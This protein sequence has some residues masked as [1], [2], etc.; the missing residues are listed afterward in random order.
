MKHIGIVGISAIGSAMCYKIIVEKASENGF[1]I[2]HP[3][4]TVHNFSFDQYFTA[5]PNTENGWSD[6]HN[7]ILDSIKKLK[8]IGS[9]FIIIPASTVHHDFSY[10][11]RKSSLPILNII[12]VTVNECVQRKFNKVAIIGT[13][14]A[15]QGKLYSEKLEANG[16]EQVIPDGDGCNT[17]NEIIYSEL[18]GGKNMPAS[19]KKIIDIVTNLNCDA[20]ILSCTELPAILSEQSLGIPVVNSIEVLAQRALEYACQ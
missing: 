19:T 9:D 10:L 8:R 17:I 3:E 2:K 15:M 6:V 14:L 1:P 12:D 18:M 13:L 4:I 7:I 5:G 11:E 20:A 16:I